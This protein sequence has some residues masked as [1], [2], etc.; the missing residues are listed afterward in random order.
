[1]L[2]I[3]SARPTEDFMG[4]STQEEEN[5]PNF[6][7]MDQKASVKKE[8]AESTTPTTRNAGGGGVGGG[9]GGLG[10]GGGGGGRQ[11]GDSGKKG[12]EGGGSFKETA[13]RRSRG[14][15]IDES[16]MF[17]TGGG[18][19]PT[20]R[21]RTDRGDN[22]GWKANKGKKKETKTLA[23]KGSRTRRP[24]GGVTSRKLW[25]RR[26]RISKRDIAEKVRRRWWKATVGAAGVSVEG[27]KALGGKEG[28]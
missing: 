8:S 18:E 10:G 1:M 5:A 2:K 14:L 13:R 6:S 15:F 23:K 28:G 26:D 4:A 12:G 7:K 19:V 9:G 24:P 20:I 16:G 17:D 22:R 3:G 27:P 11:S 21:G 25:E